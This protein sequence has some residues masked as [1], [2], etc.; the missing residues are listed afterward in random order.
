MEHAILGL[1]LLLS[2][3]TD[4]SAARSKKGP[5]KE[6]AMDM[7]PHSFDD[8]YQ[9][10]IHLM[11]AE[12]EELNRTEFA[13]ETFAEEWRN[14]TE[15]WQ[16]R[17]GRVSS[18]MVLRQDQAIAMLAYTMEGELYRVF[19]NA[20]LTAGR[21]R[22]HYLSSYPFKAL[23][24]L[25][26]RA[27]HTLRESQTQ[28]CHNVFRGVRGTRFTAQQGTVVRFG[29]FISSSLRKKVAE[30]FGL[31]TFFSVETCYGVPI[32]EFSTFPGED[33]VLIPPF[34]Q[35]RV[36]NS[37]YTEGRSFIQLRSQGKSSTYNCEF[38][39]EKRCKERPCAFSADKSSPQ[40]RS[41]WPGWA[42]LAAPHSH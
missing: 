9:G 25:L 15:K 29:Q 40:P 42:P 36:T 33:E 38:V 26:S 30:F 14:A 12:L 27:L 8:Q 21:S 20:T 28:R 31:D 2:T 16:R 1:V 37:T 11:E 34:E 7:A 3:R 19:N 24:F 18:P 4:A 32:K 22:Q 39:K 35:F 5:I 13:N 23:H 10:C 17:W 6:V 41:P